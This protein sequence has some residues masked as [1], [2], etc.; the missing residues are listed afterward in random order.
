MGVTAVVGFQAGDE[1]KGKVVDLLAKDS[2]IVARFQ[3]GAN[4]GHTIVVKGEQYISHLLPSGILYDNVR[5]GIGRGLVLDVLQLSNE[6]LEMEERAGIDLSKRMIIDDKAQL[7]LPFHRI[8]DLA[9]ESKADRGTTA[10]GIGPAYEDETARRSIYAFALKDKELLGSLVK[11][12]CELAEAKIKKVF[13]I[14]DDEFTEFFDVITE[15]EVRGNKIL[16]DLGLLKEE[17]LDFTIFQKGASFDH[18]A[19]TEVVFEK[20]KRFTGNIGNLTAEIHD[21]IKDK[22]EVL[23]EGAQGRELDKRHGV[24]PGVTSSHTIVAEAASGIGMPPYAI[25]R[26]IGIGKAYTT[27]VGTHIFPTEMEDC[28][29]STKLKKFEFGATTGRQRMVGWFDLVQGR[30]SQMLNGHHEIGIMKIDLL[31]GADELK[32]CTAY[33]LDGKQLKL[34]PSNPEDLK[35]A[36]PVYKKFPGWKDDITN[37]RKFEDLPGAAQDYL[38]FIEAGMNESSLLPMK[39]KFVGVGP[40]REQT[41]VL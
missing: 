26:I 7:L 14:S 10:R 23:L 15:K 1:G 34:P 18:E 12:S 24:Q 30:M 19:M 37:V 29:L 25:D 33:E 21:A 16:L 27:K 38:R 39:L 5:I 40:G 11:A 28:E 8:V 2:D 41:I 13:G 17:D 31:S 20:A 3:G 35:R 4:A 9:Q 22:K 32:I 36:K 6:V